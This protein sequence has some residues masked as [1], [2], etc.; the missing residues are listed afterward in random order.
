[1]PCIRSSAVCC[2]VIALSSAPSSAQNFPAHAIRLVIPFAPGGGAD[3]A[4]RIFAQRLTEQL[5][6]SVVPDN[7]AGAGGNVGAEVTA[8]AAPD[9]YTVLLTTNSIV[10]NVSLY[11]KLNYSLK[12]LAPITLSATIP[13]VLVTHPSVPAKSV[14]ELIALARQRKGGLNFGSNGSG[15]TSHLSG[16]LLN[17]MAGIDAV[18]IPYRG[19]GAVMTALLS[20]EVDMGFSVTLVVQPYIRMGRLRAIAV[21]TLKPAATMP[22]VPTL[23]SFYPGFETNVWHGFF[24][25]AGTPAPVLARLHDE[26]VKA[27]QSPQVRAALERDGAEPVGTGSSEFASIIAKD[28]D[29]YARLVRISGAKPE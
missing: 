3:I 28:I 5:G 13:L 9:G 15:T 29:K 11:P 10:V 21:T 6:Q 17:S 14:K 23:N 25:P 12:E 20:G 4:G 2:A 27:L 26:I 24:A 16:V 18:H 7:R 22:D 8:K 19:G 1:M